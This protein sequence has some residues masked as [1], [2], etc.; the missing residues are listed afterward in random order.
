MPAKVNLR[1]VSGEM[2]GQEFVFDQRDCC[3]A[4]R[5]TVCSVRVPGRVDKLISRHHCMLDVNP[6]D[7]RLS[8][9]D[10]CR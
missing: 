10:R 5:G 8:R 7:I 3:F 4:G 9:L 6:P 2:A 1:I